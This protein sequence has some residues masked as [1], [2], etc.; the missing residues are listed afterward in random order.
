MQALDASSIAERVYALPQLI[1]HRIEDQFRSRWC[2]TVKQREVGLP[3][4]LGRL[5]DPNVPEEL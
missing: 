3:S 2:T 4:K 1:S 5:V